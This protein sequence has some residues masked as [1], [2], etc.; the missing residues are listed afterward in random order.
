MPEDTAIE[1]QATELL[2]TLIPASAT[3]RSPVA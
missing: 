2:R 3:P 1:T